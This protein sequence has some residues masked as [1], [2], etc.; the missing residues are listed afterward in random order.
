MK[1]LFFYTKSRIY[2]TNL[3]QAARAVLL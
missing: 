3:V 1:E 2:Y